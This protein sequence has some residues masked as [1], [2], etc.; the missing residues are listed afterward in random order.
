MRTYGRLDVP[1]KKEIIILAIVGL[2]LF[3]PLIYSFF[4][5]ISTREV[6]NTSILVTSVLLAMVGILPFLGLD[7]LIKLRC[8]TCHRNF[9]VRRTEHIRVRD[10]ILSKQEDQVIR[11][12]TYRNTY[13]CE[14][15]D[16]SETKFENI[17]ETIRTD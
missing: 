14:Y 4:Q 1:L 13:N 8:P 15:C 3:A 5:I 11:E 12:V 9:G 10:K 16:Y 6:P 7:T 2:L 17:E